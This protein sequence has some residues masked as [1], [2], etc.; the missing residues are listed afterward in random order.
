M[1]YFERC[2]LIGECVGR[3]CGCGSRDKSR[4]KPVGT[5]DAYDRTEE[6]STSPTNLTPTSKV[7]AFGEKSHAD[8]LP[9][10]MESPIERIG[11]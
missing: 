8:T 9:N 2:E 5:F 7:K 1:C 10:K 11:K 3:G 6:R 4:K